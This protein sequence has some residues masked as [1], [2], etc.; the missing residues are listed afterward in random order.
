MEQ[1]LLSPPILQVFG[2][3]LGT[4]WTFT[5]V[6]TVLEHTTISVIHMRGMGMTGKVV[7]SAPSSNL[8]YTWLNLSNPM[9]M[10]VVAQQTSFIATSTEDYMLVT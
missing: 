3:S 7:V 8:S 1:P 5:H 2:N 6:F 10:P 9:A 4:G